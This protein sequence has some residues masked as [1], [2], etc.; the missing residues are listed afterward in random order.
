MPWYEAVSLG[1]CGGIL[2]DI[3]GI[4]KAKHGPPPQY[5]KS[6][7]F[8]ISLF[9][10]AIIGGGAAYLTEPSKV[11]EALAMGYS[12]PT[13]V[14]KLLGTDHPPATLGSVPGDPSGMYAF[15]PPRRPIPNF[16]APLQKWWASN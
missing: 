16:F 9:I 15:E 12:A 4:V 6:K 2:S 11:I 13:I 1:C 5:L 10:L 8:W 14:S 7:F 3:L